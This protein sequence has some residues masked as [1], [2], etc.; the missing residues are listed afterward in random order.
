MKQPSMTRSYIDKM[1]AAASHK[2]KQSLQD[3]GA[4]VRQ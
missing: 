4:R 3:C 2:W 1:R